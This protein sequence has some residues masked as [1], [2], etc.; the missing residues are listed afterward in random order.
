MSQWSEEFM[1][2]GNAD[3][4]RLGKDCRPPSSFRQLV[5]A[6][7]G[8]GYETIRVEMVSMLS[9]KN[10]SPRV[11]DLSVVMSVISSTLP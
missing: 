8:G 3:V 5:Y 10:H 11:C 1:K 4:T 9:R 2:T 6:F 7:G